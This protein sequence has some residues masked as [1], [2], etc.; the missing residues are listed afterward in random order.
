[1]GY[2][3]EENRHSSPGHFVS[4]DRA[5]SPAVLSAGW[6]LFL[7]AVLSLLAAAYRGP[8]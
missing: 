2:R 3:I 8:T 5:P 1:M 6:V 4:H 7:V